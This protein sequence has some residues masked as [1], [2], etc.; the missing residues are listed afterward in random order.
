[1]VIVTFFE[2]GPSQPPNVEVSIVQASSQAFAMGLPA[3]G[4]QQADAICT[5]MDRQQEI[6]QRIG[7]WKAD[8][9]HAAISLIQPAGSPGWRWTNHAV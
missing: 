2:G 4:N 3:W 1:V 7:G 9:L 5:Q 8:E 6:T